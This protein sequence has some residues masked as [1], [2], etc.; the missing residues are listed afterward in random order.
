MTD[1]LLERDDEV[2]ALAR[3]LNE[4]RRGTGSVA[5]VEAPAGLG[6][7][8]LLRELRGRADAIGMP[9]AAASGFEL[10]RDFAFGVVR[11]LFE[12]I[13]AREGDDGDLFSGAAAAA[14][15]LFDP[16]ADPEEAGQ[17][18]LPRLL[19]ALFWLTSTIAERDPLLLIVDDL[20]W[21]DDE[22]VR[23]LAFLVRRAG[24]LPIL[25]ALAT[26]PDEPDPAITPAARAELGSHAHVRVVSPQPLSREAVDE[27]VQDRF[28][29]EVSPEFSAGCAQASGGSPFLLGELVTEL[30][31]EGVEPDEA[32]AKRVLEI[33]PEAVGQ[34]VLLR[35]ARL[36]PEAARV[37]EAVAVL[38]HGAELRH[39]AALAELAL[40]EAG[41]AA[42]A[43]ADARIFAPGRPLGFLHPLLANA[44]LAQIST[45]ERAAL[46][47]RAAALL[48]EESADVERVAAHLLHTE[49]AGDPL[50]VEVLHQAGRQALGRAGPRAALAF[51]RR[52]LAE[53]PGDRA[54]LAADLLHARLLSGAYEDA[55]DFDELVGTFSAKTETVARCARELALPFVVTGRAAEGLEL[56]DRARAAITDRDLGYEVDA[57][58][59]FVAS[60]FD[61][62]GLDERI[63]RLLEAAPAGDTPAERILLAM[64][65]GLSLLVGWEPKQRV[66]MAKRALRGGQLLH[67]GGADAPYIL[68]AFAPLTALEAEWEEAEALANAAIAETQRRG[69]AIGFAMASTTR[70]RFAKLRGDLMVAEEHARNAVRVATEGGWLWRGGIVVQ[71]MLDVLVERGM[72]DDAQRLLEDAN[73]EPGPDGDAENAPVGGMVG[74]RGIL[75]LAQ[76]RMDDAFRDLS[77]HREYV[78]SHD[79][80][81]GPVD[82]AL[83][84]VLA[85]RGELEEGRRILDRDIALV[86]ERTGERWTEGSL[87]T[88]VGSIVPGE[89]GLALLEDATELL[90]PSRARLA[91]AKALVELGTALRRARKPARA[92]EPLR[93]GLELARVC[94]ARGL[95]ERARAEL[96]AAGERVRHP[97]ASGVDELTAS[98]R[99]TAA[100]AAE[101]MSNR[102]I[103]EALFVTK[104]T[105]E[106]HMTRAFRKLGVSSR[107]ELASALGERRAPEE[108]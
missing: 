57:A 53:P 38:G 50:V 36:Q 74:T 2:R 105:V 6:K 21:A 3:M 54:E 85:A 90:A 65:A 108:P 72:L 35:L 68:W 78:L 42:D 95:A 34:A 61:S 33:A 25:V 76:R 47:G 18:A 94:G 23:F 10:E 7:S 100:M 49:P 55:A 75:R 71:T 16:A 81:D 99:R 20:H 86:R 26:R 40:E 37:S 101:G 83:A 64:L 82:E 67:D 22:S 13:V 66:D 80:L 24:D 45:S 19:N 107:S 12:P 28:G 58:A 98:E 30:V 87:L 69:S 11:Q 79:G 92:R 52:A 93:D 104:K 39:A 48:R 60:Q 84:S 8:S 77:A 91:Y 102:E 5:L 43:L 32:G 97:V 29:R 70:A 73:W 59:L 1:E 103:A 56:L 14:R 9:V 62:R 15:V 41:R 44:V 88:V 4:A 17:D 96:E 63:R 27:L 89:E 51:L 46:H 106:T 31:E